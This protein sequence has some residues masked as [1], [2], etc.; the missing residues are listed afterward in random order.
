MAFLRNLYLTLLF[1]SKAV[2]A[3]PVKSTYVV[4]DTH[5]VPSRWSRVGQAHPDH[6][7]NLQIGLKQSRFDEL[8]KH[9][10]EVSDPL[11][12]R[13]GQHLTIDEVNELVRPTD[14]T[15]ELVHEWLSGDGI[16]TSQLRYS[17]A[18]DWITVRL[19]V[20]QI[21]RLLD[22]EYSTF[23]HDEDESEIVR[24]PEWS[25]PK[26]LHD[27][28]VTIQPTNSFF[29]PKPISRLSK[30]FKP[31]GI[32]SLPPPPTNASI[33]AVCNVS[34]VTPLCLRTLYGTV[35]YTVQAAGKNTMAINDFLGQINNRSD[36]SI[37]LETYRPEAAA[38]AYQFEQISIAEGTLQQSPEN[39]TQLGNETG[40]EGNLDVQT[41]LGI[42]WPTPLV[43]YST[44]G[45][46]PVFV[47][48]LFTPTDTDEPYLVWLQYILAQ[49]DLP[50]VVSTS[51]DDD[52][53]TVP[54]SYASQACNMFA[55]LGARG[56]SV[57]FG[58]GDEGVGPS[59]YC[60]SNDGTNSS[61]FLPQFPSSCPYVTS[62]GATKN[63]EPEGTC[64]FPPC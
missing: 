27:H 21:E 32:A 11:H 14:D 13:Y 57:F 62:V 60:V 45:L 58:S 54:Y 15:L 34:L 1:A 52:E 18:H 36:T 16:E 17:P 56:V 23:V 8:E 41:M 35:N 22:T 44:G 42:A 61:T 24:A 43:A 25:L 59:G 48:D 63:F 3:S 4:K 47:P 10:Y 33:S 38:A 26:H 55:Q 30:P 19:P 39:A 37:Y 53:Q 40:I 5:H 29:R 49:S 50:S 51:Y 31:S 28:I 2:F 12:N 46:N 9:L 6:M 7:I 64:S 20:G